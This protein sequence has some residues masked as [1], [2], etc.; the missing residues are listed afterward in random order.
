MEALVPQRTPPTFMAIDHPRASAMRFSERARER[1]LLTGQHHKVSV[2][3]H[4]I[5]G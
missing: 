5:P 4:Q 1:T 2:I 3:T